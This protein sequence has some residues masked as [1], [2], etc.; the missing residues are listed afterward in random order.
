MKQIVVKSLSLISAF[1]LLLG[2]FSMAACSDPQNTTD[3]EP[4]ASN[5]ETESME[6]PRAT[7]DTPN[8]KY[9]GHTFHVSSIAS[10]THYTTLDPEKLSGEAVN[11]ALY[12][13][14]RKI[15]AE[16][17][18]V[19]DCTS[20]D[21]G[22]NFTL[23]EKQV[24]AGTDDDYDMIMQICRN[25]FS[26]AT[27][28]LLINYKDLTYVDID[29][30]Y[31]FD[32]INEQFTIGGN[33][34]FAYGYDSINVF[35][36]SSALFFNK[37]IVNEMNMGN[38]Y[39]DVR[40]KNWTYDRLYTLANEATSDENGDGVF[41]LGEDV[42]GL[43][44]NYDRTIPCFWVA[45]GE[46]LI[47]KDEEDLPAYAA[48]GNERMINIMQEA[49]T[50]FDTD[51]FDVYG[52]DNNRLS[53][54][55]D[56][57]ALFLSTGIGELSKLKST[58]L[59]YGVLPWPIYDKNQENYVSRCGDAWLHCVPSN[60]EN[61]ERTSAIMQALAYYSADTVYKAYYDN[62]LTSKYVRDPESVEMMQIILSTLSIDLGDT[63]WF[64]N[65]RF[66]LTKEFLTKKGNIGITSTFKSYERIA[67]REIKKVMD[68]LNDQNA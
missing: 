46:K 29:K 26:A 24:M 40:N 65:L 68:F 18:I 31:Y 11:D 15:E 49:A 8:V 38:L 56:G 43:I 5:A 60:A 32:D 17:D 9:G 30:N 67:N 13:R 14:N 19:I 22:T 21:I 61:P 66:P 57:K 52:A 47:N 48:N 6:D 36:L 10:E 33:T 41:T 44:G 4:S 34:F 58:E 27:R 53:A 3:T 23:L 51:A 25:A 7:L 1:C 62:A 54:F 37:E 45:A 59:D 39:D 12:E 28:N 64:E 55:M 50:H 16:Y 63:I 2:C 42:L 35:S 20:T